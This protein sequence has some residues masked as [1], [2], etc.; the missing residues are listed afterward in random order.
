MKIKYASVALIMLLSGAHSI[1]AQESVS[2]ETSVYT[3]HLDYGN[4]NENNNLVGIEYQNNDWYLNV[5]KF[6]NSYYNDSKTIGSGYRFY[7]NDIIDLDILF[8]VVNG[9]TQEQIKSICF[10]ENCAYVAPRITINIPI[11]NN[12]KFKTSTQLFGTAVIV[13]TGIKYTF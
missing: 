8:G 12:L 4:Y 10:G 3:N 7:N 9:Y 2:I 13:T 11:T 1:H 5:T 6:K